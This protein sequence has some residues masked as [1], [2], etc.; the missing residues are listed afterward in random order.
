MTCG[1]DPLMIG[2][3]PLRWGDGGVAAVIVHCGTSLLEAN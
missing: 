3:I 2:N 1:S